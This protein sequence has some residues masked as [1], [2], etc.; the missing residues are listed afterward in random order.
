MS[1]GIISIILRVKFTTMVIWQKTIGSHSPQIMRMTG[2]VCLHSLVNETV[3]NID[4]GGGGGGAG[5]GEVG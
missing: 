5:G 2:D 4:G 1:I 3:E